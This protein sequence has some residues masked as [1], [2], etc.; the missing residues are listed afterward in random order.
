M[1]K[2]ESCNEVT[3]CEAP[4]RETRP[5]HNTGKHVPYSFGKESVFFNVPCKPYNN[6]GAGDG[7]YGL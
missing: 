6:E 2:Y 7:A 4:T 1:F 5:D 3:L